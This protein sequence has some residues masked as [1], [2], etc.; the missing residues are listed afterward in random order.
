MHSSHWSLLLIVCTVPCMCRAD[1][2]KELPAIQKGLR[3][4][5][6][7][8]E[9][10]MATEDPPAGRQ[11]PNFD[12]RTDDERDQAAIVGEGESIPAVI[13]PK[14]AHFPAGGG[15]PKAHGTV[16]AD[17]EQRGA[18]GCEGDAPDGVAV[19]QAHGPQ[20]GERPR[21]QRIAVRVRA[22]HRLG[23]SRRR[24]VGQAR[25]GQPRR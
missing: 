7:Q 18:V 9:Q 16:V 10:W 17:G 15:I 11:I 1:S 3:Y 6:A 8:G 21:R 23:G 24:S 22:R 14:G 12:G 5:E 25:E 13:G 20:S 19:A 2:P 4:L